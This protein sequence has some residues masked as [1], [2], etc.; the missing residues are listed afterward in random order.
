MSQWYGEDTHSRSYDDY[1]MVMILSTAYDLPGGTRQ[2]VI[3]CNMAFQSSYFHPLLPSMRDPQADFIPE[4]P[5]S[6]SQIMPKSTSSESHD[7]DAVF[8]AW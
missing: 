7:D 3:Q 2:L 5:Y 6:Q 1:C 4:M 8:G